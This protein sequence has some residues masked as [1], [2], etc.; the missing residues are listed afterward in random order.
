MIQPC[1][2]IG[3]SP[4]LFIIAIQLVAD[5]V[6]LRIPVDKFFI[7]GYTRIAA[8]HLLL[9]NQLPI[10]VINVTVV[11]NPMGYQENL[12]LCIPAKIPWSFGNIEVLVD[13]ERSLS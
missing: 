4:D 11:F 2:E 9:S 10:A 1:R 12:I 7:A 5:M 8:R 6:C 13:F 3:D